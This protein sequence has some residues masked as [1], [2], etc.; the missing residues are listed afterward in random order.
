MKPTTVAVILCGALVSLTLACSHRPADVVK[1]YE[2][3]YN[4]GDL[5]KVLSLYAEDASFRVPGLIDL[6]GTEAL[7]GLAEYDQ[8]LHT[9]LQFSQMDVRGDTVMCQVKETNDWIETAGI[10]EAY[11]DGIIVVRRGLISAIDAKF[12]PETD[13]AFRRTMVAL[14]EW[15]RAERPELLSEMMPQGRFVYNAENANKNLSLLREYKQSV[16]RQ[17]IQPGWEKLSE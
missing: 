5:D 10:S 16:R 13:R 14:M 9:N 3:A 8:A 15:A 12:T 4:R 6:Q 11:Y 7:R 17:A 2:K 1:A